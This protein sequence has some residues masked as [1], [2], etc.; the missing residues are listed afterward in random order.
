MIIIQFDTW[1]KPGITPDIAPTMQ[2]A[3]EYCKYAL[4]ITDW[5]QL[6]DVPLTASEKEA[7]AVYR[8]QL[9][10]I[11]NIYTNPDDIIWPVPP[12]EV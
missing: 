5:T 10:D 7:W 3:D 4:A 6:P 8:Q 12:M 2:D 11:P 1:Y 9:R